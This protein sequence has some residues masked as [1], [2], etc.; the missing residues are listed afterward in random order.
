MY[1]A[2]LE[3]EPGIAFDDKLVIEDGICSL[4]RLADLSK[5]LAKIKNSAV[6][7]LNNVR[8]K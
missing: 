1:E 5:E 7:I 6:F 8:R 2:S 3:K 4:V